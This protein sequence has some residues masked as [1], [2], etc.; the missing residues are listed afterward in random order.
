M[1][2]PALPADVERAERITSSGPALRIDRVSKTFGVSKALDD[3]SF[4]VGHGEIHALLGGNGS[5]KS[6]LIKI[7]AG[8]Y[9][10]DE[11]GGA[12]EFD[13]TRVEAHSMTPAIARD[14]RLRFVHQNPG[15]FQDLTVADNVAMRSGYPTR[16][17]AIRKRALHRH[18]AALLDAFEID[19]KPGDVLGDL[20]PADQ[21]MIAIARALE[22]SDGEPPSLLVLDEP[23]ASLPQGEVDVLLAAL[24]RRAHAGQGIIYVS[25]RIDEVM[26]ISDTVTVLRDGE[27]IVTRRAEGLTE[28]SLTEYIAGRSIERLFGERPDETSARG[29]TVLTVREL[30][31]GPL[32]NVSFDLHE[33][34]ILG[35]AGLL[36]SGRTELL[37]MIFGAMRAERGEIRLRDALV[38]GGLDPRPAMRQGIAYVPEDRALDAS[39]PD[40]DVETNLSMAQVGKYLRGVFMSTK[41]ERRDALASIDG[42]GIKPRSTSAVFS[43]L[44]GGNQ[45]KVVVARWLR[46]NPAVLL[47]DEPTQGVDVGAR[48]DIYSAIRSATAQGMAVILVSSDFEELAHACDRVIVIRDGAIT[49]EVLEH[50]LD[51]EILTYLTYSGKENES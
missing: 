19:A 6:T 43:T 13:G 24:R 49:A 22:R 11:D 51:R 47:L 42:F 15:L 46:R 41:A 35:V 7:L 39:F 12:L 36:G 25:H 26:S 5:G 30:A 33:G 28:A 4:E 50:R 16:I 9:R 44:S 27:H 1:N 29:A 20:R 21:T 8:V 37:R 32:A 3:V 48:A 2:S 18:V 38:V 40:L 34:E 23:T 31:G 17:G 14:N 10:G 45:Q